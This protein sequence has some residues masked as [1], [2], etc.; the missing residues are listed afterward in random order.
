MARFVMLR[1]FPRGVRLAEE[2]EEDE[3][4]KQK[5]LNIEELVEYIKEDLKYESQE[6]P[7]LLDMDRKTFYEFSGESK[8][9]TLKTGKDIELFRICGISDTRDVEKVRTARVFPKRPETLRAIPPI[10]P[11]KR[12]LGI[13]TSLKPP[14]ILVEKTR[15][16]AR[17]CLGEYFND[18]YFDTE[19]LNA[20]KIKETLIDLVFTGKQYKLD[21]DEMR[22]PLTL[23]LLSNEAV[24]SLDDLFE[25]E[26]KFD[27]K[28][29][30]DAY[31]K[32]ADM[33]YAVSNLLNF[34]GRSDLQS[35][36]SQMMLGVQANYLLEEVRDPNTPE[37]KRNIDY[38]GLVFGSFLELS[39]RNYLDTGTHGELFSQWFP[40]IR[41]KKNFSRIW[42]N[43]R[44]AT[45][46]IDGLID[47][48]EDVYNNILSPL[49]TYIYHLCTEDER[50]TIRD[51]VSN[52]SYN[53]DLEGIVKGYSNRLLNN[54]KNYNNRVRP[55]TP[56]V[57][58]LQDRMRNVIDIGI[59]TS[60][61]IK[62]GRKEYDDFYS[63]SSSELL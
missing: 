62:H 14:E 6:S 35:I 61:D 58:T 37:A 4:R 15:S 9:D 44:R 20:Y 17:K 51:S 57:E 23:A 59:H 1:S 25:N 3:E 28:K 45:D 16:E 38:A 5:K 12:F 53:K 42:N 24:Y 49:T 43:S 10:E 29:A 21:W 11:E 48:K 46:I 8:R 33:F 22:D 34:K 7:E 52:A 2:R 41:E 63:D 54:I 47:L 55:R 50:E 26:D 31:R 60:E 56:Q 40:E 36:V 30:K 18:N 19:F 13:S 27:K 32:Q 39:D